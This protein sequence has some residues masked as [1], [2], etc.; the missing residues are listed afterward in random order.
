MGYKDDPE[1]MDFLKEFSGLMATHF[2][3]LSKEEPKG[4]KSSASSTSASADSAVRSIGNGA[5]SNSRQ[6]TATPEPLPIEDPKVA[7]AFSDPEVQCLIANLRAGRPM[8]MHEIGR[9]NP[10]LF[11]KVKVLLDSG[12]LSMEH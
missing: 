1:V 11:E 2:D 9:R 12:V 10:K 6:A 7:A 5:K 4:S 8:E 3:V